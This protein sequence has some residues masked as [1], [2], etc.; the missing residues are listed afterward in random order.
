MIKTEI[1]KTGR[2]AYPGF[3]SGNLSIFQEKIHYRQQA[4]NKSDSSSLNIEHEKARFTKALHKTKLAINRLITSLSKYQNAASSEAKSILEAHLITLKDPVFIENIY[5]KINH[6]MTAEKSVKLVS[7]EFITAFSKMEEIIFQDKKRDIEDIQVRLLTQLGASIQQN[8]PENTQIIWAGSLRPQQVIYLHK[9][10][11]QGIILSNAAENSHEIIL[12]KA[13]QIPSIYNVRYRPRLKRGESVSAALNAEKGLLY[14]NPTHEHTKEIQIKKEKS[15]EDEKK[16]IYQDKIVKTYDGDSIKISM[17]LDLIEELNYSP[18]EKIAGIGLFR[19]EF[20][21]LSNP[22]LTEYDQI[23]YYT[24]V[25]ETFPN[26]EIVIRLFDIGGDKNFYMTN[27]QSDEN[28][29]GVRSIRYLIKESDLL[30]TQIRAI[31]KSNKKG[32]AIILLPMISIIE[33]VEQIK[34]IITDIT[35]EINV[36]YPKIGVLI[37]TPGAIDLMPYM[38]N[39]VDFYSVG[40]NDLL[41]YI[42]A[43]D[44]TINQLSNIY[45]PLHEGLWNGLER[46]LKN[47]QMAPV[48]IPV[49]ICGELPS[50]LEFLTMLIGLGYRNFS[51]RPSFIYRIKEFIPQLNTKMAKFLLDQIRLIPTISK[52]SEYLKKNFQKFTNES[53]NK[54]NL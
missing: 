28:F 22:Q 4:I 49:S 12:M 38:N 40:T 8:L 10:G 18:V 14:F 21:L 44:R 43:S 37:E 50:K 26:D 33:E 25:F 45:N 52:R 16:R 36:S 3:A 5:D 6:N 48:K 30:R 7:N 19:T 1:K 24:K 27:R 54:Q 42:T 23:E 2:I 31:L 11:I 17:N 20:L 39:M 53:F 35:K 41:Q 51:V 9:I 15:I 29:L 46:I 34:A 13:L 47:T 32:N